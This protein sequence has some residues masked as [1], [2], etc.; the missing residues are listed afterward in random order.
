MR[1]P[2]NQEWILMMRGAACL[3][4]PDQFMAGLLPAK[5]K[6]PEFI[7][8]FIVIFKTILVNIQKLKA[9]EVLDGLEM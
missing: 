1:L 2:M 4:R 9:N 5:Q 3:I 7:R 8:V 6:H